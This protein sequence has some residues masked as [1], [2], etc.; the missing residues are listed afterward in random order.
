M[1]ASKGRTFYYHADANPLGGSIT[2]PFE[3]V[4]STQASTSVSQAGGHAHDS[5]GEFRVGHVV[6][7]SRA[8]SEIYATSHATDGAWVSQVTAV[9]ED[10][11]VLD[12]VRVKRMI[13]RLTVRHP[14]AGY[15]PFIEFSGCQYEGVT[16]SGATLTPTL[17]LDRFAR[18]F[19]RG[20]VL[21]ESWLH[22]DGLVGHAVAHSKVVTGAEGAP[23][24]VAPRYGWVAEEKERQDRGH[25]VC[26]L[27]RD[28]GGA[29]PKSSFG[30]VMQV[31]GV[32]NL[33]FGE[34]T[35]DQGAFGLTMLRVEMGCLAD[36]TLGFATAHSNGRPYP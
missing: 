36:G 6:S 14:H 24:W 32:G 2:A 23:D 20:D 30:H 17:D 15:H 5:V 28:I 13:S 4:I 25:V 18:R 3:S 29:E 9:V 10:L 34:L 16:V 22:H 26:S 19:K 7:I 11:N 21:Q 27:V 35:V 8:W 1:N 33:F 31:A 12:I